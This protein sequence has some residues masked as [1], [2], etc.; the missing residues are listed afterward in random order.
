[1]CRPAMVRQRDFTCRPSE[2]LASFCFDSGCAKAAEDL[3]ESGLL[4]L[5]LVTLP[6]FVILEGR[7]D[8]IV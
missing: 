3:G 2:G 6:G 5:L 4:Q 8:A 7:G 1:M